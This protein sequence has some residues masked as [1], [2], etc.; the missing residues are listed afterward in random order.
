MLRLSNAA[1]KVHSCPRTFTA[2]QHC[3][4]ARIQT[5]SISSLVLSTREASGHNVEPERKEAADK[6]DNITTWGKIR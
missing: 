4:Y 6:V 1:Q 3:N 2:L 5:P